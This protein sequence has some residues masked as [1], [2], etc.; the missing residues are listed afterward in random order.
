MVSVAEGRVV[1]E[2]V[3]IGMHLMCHHNRAAVRATKARAIVHLELDLFVE[4]EVATTSE[5]SKKLHIYFLLM[6]SIALWYIRGDWFFTMCPTIAYLLLGMVVDLW[7]LMVIG[8]MLEMPVAL[9]AV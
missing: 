9:M 6:A 1:E 3:Q 8:L 4:L 2:P 5:K 7:V